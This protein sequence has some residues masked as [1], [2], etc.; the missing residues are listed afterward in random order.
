MLYGEIKNK[1]PKQDSIF[2]E[3]RDALKNGQAG[4]SK[5]PKDAGEKM[6]QEFHEKEG[7]VP[8]HHISAALQYFSEDYVNSMNSSKSCF[9]RASESRTDSP[10]HKQELKK[11]LDFVLRAENDFK[12]S[13]EI[14]P[15]TDGFL[16]SRSKR[17]VYDEVNEKKTKLYLAEEF[18]SC[19]AIITPYYFRMLE[20]I[21][22][23]D[24]ELAKTMRDSIKSIT[25]RKNKTIDFQ[26]D[27]IL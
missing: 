27:L 21:Q 20:A 19:Y 17:L 14:S 12:L 9:Y 3:V 23:N 11:S 13:L 8:D 22:E 26:E 2:I 24:F 16:R 5:L 15:L 1:M 18:P 10:E 25:F 6:L 7:D 4:L